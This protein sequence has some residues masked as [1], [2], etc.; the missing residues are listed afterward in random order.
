MNSFDFK[1]VTLNDGMMKKVLD[2][3]L[4]FYLKI[5]NDNILKYMRESAGKPAPGIF[6]TGWYPNSRGIALIGQWLSAYSRMYAIS[7]DE[8]FRQKA[9]YLADEFWDC[10]E[11]AQHTAPF[12]TSRSH[13]DVEKL[14]R[15]HCDL[16]LYCKYPCAK[17]RAGYLI[18]FAA[19]NLTA[20]NIF[21][22]NSTEWYTLAESFWDA[23]EILEIPRAKQMAERF[24]YREFWDLFYKDADPFPNVRRLAFIPNSAMPTV[25]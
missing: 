4:A 1:E 3:T 23:F 8:A 5:P 13:Y 16:F 20:E 15:A 25:M 7:G 18:D 10:Y 2:E 6:Y 19:D 14:L 24:E 9:V 22:D 17:E 11:S 21:G 12:L